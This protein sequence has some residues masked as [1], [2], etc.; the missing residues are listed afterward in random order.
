M[1]QGRA[2]PVLSIGAPHKG[3]AVSSGL[4]GAHAYRRFLPNQFARL[5][6]KTSVSD[7]RRGDSIEL[8]MTILFAD[9]RDFTAMSESMTPRETFRFINA[10]L[11]EME[12]ALFQSHGFID[13]YIGDAIMGIFPGNADDALN[14]AFSM[15]QR[16]REFNATRRRNGAAPIRIGIGLNTGFAMAG[17]IGGSH[18]VE[19]TVIG[20][21]VNLASRLQ[22][23]T[24]T[25]GAALLISEHVLYSLK[26]PALRDIR[27]V[28]R[29]RVK[30]KE[31]PQ[32]VYEVFAADPFKLKMAKRRNK[33]MFEEALANYHCMDIPKARSLLRK[34]LAICPDDMAGR[35][36]AE[37]CARF[38]KTGIHE[39]T[40][41]I[42]MPIVWDRHY[43]I[44][45]RQID[46]QHRELFARANE[47]VSEI[48]DAKKGFQVEKLTT[49]L[50][51]YVVEHFETEEQIM[52][53]AKYP[54]LSMQEQQHARFKKDFAFL[55]AELRKKL[56]TQRTFMLFKVQ[57]LVVDWLANH[58]MKLDRHFGKFLSSV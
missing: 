32:S 46:A 53:E 10:F 14:A 1:K 54:L 23:L 15:L 13:K 19:T 36:Y 50:N 39:G 25:Y 33:S 17:A 3:S 21:A 57:L 12:P 51:S 20:D 42:G 9:I 24:K 43:K 49:F 44:N 8:N 29:V 7:I 16:L 47:F 5:L 58:T 6:G 28:D 34:Y 55:E 2:N 22:S 37:R 48:R 4:D 11:K 41:E 27:F 56:D 38:V 30:G 40:G 18:R 31:Q 26:E 35:V 45:H 52:R